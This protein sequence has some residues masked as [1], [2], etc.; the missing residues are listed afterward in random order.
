MSFE[1][2]ANETGLSR[3]ELAALYGVSRQTIHTWLVS[4]GP[5]AGGHTARMA[6]TVTNTLLNAVRRK[7]LPLPAM[8]KKDRRARVASMA[9]TAQGLKPAPIR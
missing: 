4:T 3:T 9:V 1:R 5:R 6:E 2:V 7:I 8:D